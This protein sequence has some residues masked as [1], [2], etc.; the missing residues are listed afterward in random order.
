[1][2]D[3]RA[4]LFFT[5]LA[6]PA[7]AQTIIVDSQ[8]RPG[9]QYSQISAAVDA[10]PDGAQLI[11][12]D[13]TYSP[14]QIRNKSLSLL[15][16][17]G[18]LVSTNI[19]QPVA[20]D[21][22]DL[23]AT[24][25]V[26]IRQIG[27]TTTLGLLRLNVRDCAGAVTIDACT[28]DRS[29]ASQNGGKIVIANC[30]HVV[31]HNCVLDVNGLV[32]AAIDCFNSN[33]VID[34]CTLQSTALAVRQGGGRIQINNSRILKAQS[35]S[36]NSALL[37][38]AGGEMLVH[39]G[40][41]IDG[42]QNSMSAA[43]AGTGTLVLDPDVQLLNMPK[44]A[45]DPNITLESRAIPSV[46]SGTQPLGGTAT[47]TLQVP[48][49]GVGF[50]FVGLEASPTQFPGIIDPIWFSHG[51]LEAMGSAPSITGDYSVP[52]APWVAGLVLRWQGFVLDR[53]G[54]V[55]ASNPS[56]YVHY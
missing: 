45:I 19:F 40:S 51:S 18:A 33:L 35:L 24:K 55:A 10:A 13:G 25:N 21:V 9:T 56:A 32:D 1:M 28:F 26:A 30:D 3:P 14:F 20:I 52:N 27:F 8:L 41:T 6:V 49:N 54:E 48:A 53:N 47:A 34:E 46:S 37:F 23:D 29:P 11:V 5:V 17:P 16:E 4:V 22:S 2:P 39:G 38:L 50:L 12:R 42:S 43:A 7:A 31:V 44:P 15:C 36:L